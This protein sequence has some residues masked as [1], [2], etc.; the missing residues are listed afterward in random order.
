MEIAIFN[1]ITTEGVITSIAENSKKYHVGFYADMNNAPERKLVKESASEIGGIIKE[2]EAARISITKANTLAVNKEHKLILER[3]TVANA[4]FQVLIDEYT[5]D[6]K[7]ILDAEKARKKAVFLAEQEE[8]DH[9]YALLMDEKFN[10]DIL[11]AERD[12]SKHE[13]EIKAQ[14][15]I[16]MKEQNERLIAQQK[17]AFIDAD[18]AKIKGEWL[19]IELEAHA[20]NDK[21]I[22]DAWQKHQQQLAETARLEAVE[23]ERLA[24]IERQRLAQKAIDDEAAR[25]L[26]DVNHVRSVNRAIYKSFIAAGLTTE[27]ATLATQA[28]IDM[29]ISHTKINY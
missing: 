6:R 22:S 19:A 27:C 29:T 15:V 14:A 18:L 10:N 7:V 12:K 2:L 9:E 21:M 1:K 16:D 11:T 26:A 28:L 20:I 24:G 17:Q 8:V 23:T 4:P 25:K 13:A 3:L 5:A